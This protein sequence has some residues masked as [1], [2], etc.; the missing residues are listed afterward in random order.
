MGR[1]TDMTR[2]AGIGASALSPLLAAVFAAGC[3]VFGGA[4]SSDA[5][6]PAGPPEE[7]EE[8]A[9]V[10]GSVS[11]S[12]DATMPVGALLEERLLAGDYESVLALYEADSVLHSNEDATFRAA[13]A[14]ARADH[15]A[16]DPERAWELF[17]GLLER[18]PDTSRRFEVEVYL[19]ILARERELRATVRRL[20]RELQQ[21]KAIDLGQAPAGQP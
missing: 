16:Y 11:E 10:P 12:D 2:F 21:L 9:S 8:P 6:S 13:L 14:A 7:E 4:P 20:E 18:H 19:D 15:P 17:N 1:T 5:G 3:S